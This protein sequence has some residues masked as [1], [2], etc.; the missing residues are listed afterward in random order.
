METGVKN[1]KAPESA[2][3]LGHWRR[4]SLRNSP[5]KLSHTVSN[6]LIHKLLSCW[7][8]LLRLLAI[9]P[10]PIHND[11]I[12][13][14]TQSVAMP[15][16]ATELSPLAVSRL[17]SVGLWAVGGVGGL[18][19]HVNARGARS[20]ILRVVVG[21]KRRDMGLGGYPDVGLA[22]ARQKAREARLKIEQGTDPILMRRQAKSELMALQASDKT[23][24]QAAGEYIRIHAESWANDKHRKQW[25]STLSAYAF[26]VIGKLSLRDIRQEHILKIL[27]PIWT[28]KTETATRIRGRLE[29]ILDWAKVR[30]LRGGENP[31]AWKGHLDHMLPAPTRL[32]NVQH[33]PAV[34][35][36]DMPA[37]MLQ[38]RQAAGIAA[39]ALDF[40]I[41][42]AA[43]S[44]EVRGVAWDE[45]NLDEAI[46]VVPAERMKMKREH[47]VPLSKPALEILKR[48]PRMES[49]DLV[50]PAPRSG[51]MSD[52]TMAAVLK[53]MGVKATVHGFRSSFRDWCGDYTNYPRDLAEQCLAH[54]AD[55]PVEAAYR[56]GDALERRREIMREWAGFLGSIN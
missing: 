32:K 54:E 39:Q 52:A 4:R 10:N 42:T 17:K 36:K 25:E 5:F 19:L 46:W 43:R 55:D 29:S 24:E 6:A 49:T 45:V 7:R 15:R 37:F 44:G 16:K 9:S 50:F 48:Q 38:L 14:G 35:V 34:P 8:V 28:E 12:N 3:L 30:G 31:A 27:E 41:L 11:G 53:R 22:D 23:F 51:V 21:E 33:H 18:Y 13:V 1:K 40:L 26:P 20:W 2:S 47:R 56:R